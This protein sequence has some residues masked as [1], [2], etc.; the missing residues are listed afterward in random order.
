MNIVLEGPDNG[1]KSTL[2]K[3]LA[4]QTGR[5]IIRGKGP[6]A[7]QSLFDR[8]TEFD[9]LDNVIFDRHAC[10]SEPIY[11]PICRAADDNYPML[12]RGFYASAPFFIY[13]RADSLVG[14]VEDHASDTAEHLAALETHYAQVVKAY[15]RWAIEHAHVI[16]RKG[17]TSKA[18]I[19][20]LIAAAEQSRAAAL[21]YEEHA[22]V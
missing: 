21:M 2:A 3:Y 11:G 14:H 1:G 9:D 7:G 19:V 22:R 13:C 12:T 17:I 15:D 6:C 18:L 8:F 16:Y 5:T 20:H 4:T 10:V